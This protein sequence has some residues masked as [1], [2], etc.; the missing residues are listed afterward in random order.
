[1][2]M[3]LAW[4]YAMLRALVLA[5]IRLYISLY[6][7]SPDLPPRP[8]Y[9]RPEER[10]LRSLVGIPSSVVLKIQSTRHCRLGGAAGTRGGGAHNRPDA[11]HAP[12]ELRLLLLCVRRLM[13]HASVGE[14]SVDGHGSL[15]RGGANLPRRT[16]YATLS[17]RRR[18]PDRTTGAT[19]RKRPH[20][21]VEI[22]DREERR[23]FWGAAGHRGRSRG[24]EPHADPA[25][26]EEISGLSQV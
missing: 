24:S 9:P 10:G 20:P 8:G 1:M 2:L 14:N 19:S 16:V 13:K 7:I 6:S 21:R 3:A 12:V 15:L 17:D 18:Q 5:A 25:S 22:G 26:H 11:T 23:A 4:L